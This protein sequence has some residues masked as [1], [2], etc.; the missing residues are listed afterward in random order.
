M[1]RSEK[2]WGLILIAPLA[3]GLL[4]FVIV[5]VLYSLFVA[6][7]EY[8]LIN[9]PVFTGMENLKTLVTDP[10]FFKSLGNTFLNIIGVPIAMFISLTAALMLT[11]VKALSGF[12]KSVFFLPAIC[13]SVAVT[14]MWK[15]MLD[16]NYGIV[17][18]ALEHLGF[19]KILFLADN[20]AM[21]SMITMGV[22]GGIGV[23][24]LLYFAA[25][26]NVPSVYYEA[27]MIDGA[28]AWHQFWNITMPAISPI[29]LY[30]LVTQVIGALQD[31]TRFMV[32]SGN[33][34]SEDFTTAGVYVYQQAFTFGVPG[35]ASMV[36]WALGLIII[37]FT[38]LNFGLSNKW[39]SYD[40]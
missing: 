37:L 14:F 20:M 21:P 24:V 25:L 15:Y 32:M 1:R 30:I 2:I 9:P 11:K 8:D 28:N 16:Y 26:K 10:Y 13:S 38:A 39:V 18:W 5:P 35:Y 17:N 3:I 19:Q 40:A 31:S 12:F 7:S 6:F 4:A 23:I 22:W 34:A 27:A 29:T 36:A 33:G